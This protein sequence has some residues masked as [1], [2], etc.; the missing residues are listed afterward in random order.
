MAATTITKWMI[1]SLN[2]FI[3]LTLTHAQQVPCFFI[4]GDSQSDNGNNNPLITKAKAD[5]PP[6]GVDFPGAIPTGRFTNG[7]NIADCLAEFLEFPHPIPPFAATKGPALLKGLNYASGAAGILD[8]SGINLGDRLCMNRQLENHKA[9]IAQIAPLLGNQTSA[10]VYLNQCLYVVNIGSNDYINNY[11]QQPPSPSSS[12]TPD[13][14]ADELIATFSTQLNSLYELGS[15]KVAVFGVG[16]IGCIPQEILLYPITNG[17][18]CVDDINI[19]VGIFNGKLVSLIND[20]NTKLPNAQFTYIN[21]TSIAL[22]GPGPAGVTEVNA[23]CCEVQKAGDSAPGQC[24][25]NGSVCE[26]RDEYIFFDNFH[27]TEI[28]NTF[29]ASRAYRAFL[30][31]DTSPVDIDHLVR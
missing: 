26:N 15:R 14:F 25:P 8:N 11:Y 4:F 1:L 30:L 13:A 27:P 23:P 29:T 5:Y 10:D 6:Y 20:L 28:S 16:L 12:L 2:M 31:T 22:G 9:T 18:P 24:L 3:I 21:M 19:A 17:S 7:K